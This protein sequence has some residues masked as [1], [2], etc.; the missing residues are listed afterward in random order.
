MTLSNTP[1]RYSSNISPMFTAHLT[2]MSLKDITFRHTCSAYS[3]CCLTDKRKAVGESVMHQTTALSGLHV[4]QPKNPSFDRS[5]DAAR[6]YLHTGAAA[7]NVIIVRNCIDC[8]LAR[9]GTFDCHLSANTCQGKGRST[10]PP[11]LRP[12]YASKTG[13]W[14]YKLRKQDRIFIGNISYASEEG[15]WQYKLRGSM[16]HFSVLF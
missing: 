2:Q 12:R 13:C 16:I 1:G 7:K 3:R 11:L 8:H 10:L 14:Q 6:L 4:L 9:G 15:C 5:S